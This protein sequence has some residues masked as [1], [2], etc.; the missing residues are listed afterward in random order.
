MRPKRLLLAALLG[1]VNAVITFIF[2]VLVNV[3]QTLIWEQAAQ[4]V[5]LSMP[6]FTLLICTLGGR[7]RSSW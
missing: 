6:V 3:G 5:G 2:L 1:L 4:A 7:V